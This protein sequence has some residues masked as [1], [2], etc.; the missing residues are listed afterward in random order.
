MKR[1]LL[2]ICCGVCA[3]GAI[4]QLANEGHTI[5]GLFFNPNIH[6]ETEYLRRKK[7]VQDVALLTHMPLLESAYEPSAWFQV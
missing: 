3:F 4:E 1:V 5:K 6:P 7:C 2:H